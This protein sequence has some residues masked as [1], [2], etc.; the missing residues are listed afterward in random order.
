MSRLELPPEFVF[1]IFHD[2]L[3]GPHVRLSFLTDAL[4]SAEN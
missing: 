2:E 3:I 1:A 4:G